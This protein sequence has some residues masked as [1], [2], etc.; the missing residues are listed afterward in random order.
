MGVP[1]FVEKI[2]FFKNRA[3]GRVFV[4]N[5]IFKDNENYELS[6]SISLEYDKINNLKGSSQHSIIINTNEVILY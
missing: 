2:L 6:N 5:W 4:G 3:C 1:E